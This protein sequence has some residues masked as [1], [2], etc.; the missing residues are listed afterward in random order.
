M[1]DIKID[2]G[3]RDLL[4]KLEALIKAALHKLVPDREVALNTYYKPLYEEL[5]RINANYTG[6]FMTIREAT[7]VDQLDGTWYLPPYDGHGGCIGSYED[8]SSRVKQLKSQF[9]VSRLDPGCWRSQFRSKARALLNGAEGPEARRFL[10]AVLMY[11]TE[12]TPPWNGD[13]AGLDRQVEH[14]IEHGELTPGGPDSAVDSPSFRLS[15]RFEQ[16]ASPEQIREAADNAW[17]ELGLRIALVTQMYY[18]LE[19]SIRTPRGI[20]RR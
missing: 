5:Q 18:E 4:D 12:D 2:M 10:A 13:R 1:T 7:A 8:A 15:G 9:E 16:A 3:V 11:F 17:K 20:G 6:M 19:Q 14:I